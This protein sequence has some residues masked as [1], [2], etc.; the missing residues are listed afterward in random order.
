MFQYERIRDLFE[1]SDVT[2]SQFIQDTGIS[3]SNLYVW[4][5]GR[6]VPG[7]DKLEIIADYFNVPM[8]YF[9]EREV[10]VGREVGHHVS[11]NGNSVSGDITIAECKTEVRHLREILEEKERTIR[12]LM[13]MMDRED[14]PIRSFESSRYISDEG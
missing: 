7:A 1:R 12:L 13:R 4:M 5:G 10:P 2:Q 9:F 11:G 3:K 14:A 8:D 6:S